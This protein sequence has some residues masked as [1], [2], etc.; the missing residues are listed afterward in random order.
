MLFRTRSVAKS[1]QTT[2]GAVMGSN[3]AVRAGV[4][5]LVALATCLALLMGCGGGDGGSTVGVKDGATTA[6][7]PISEGAAEATVDASDHDP[8]AL[9]TQADAE[10]LLG[11]TPDDPEVESKSCTWRTKKN[12]F[13]RL[14]I[15]EDFVYETYKNDSQPVTGVGDEAYRVDDDIY[16]KKGS[17]FFHV[18]IQG[19]GERDVEPVFQQ[20]AELVLKKL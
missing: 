16:V 1:C 2:K 15:D 4:G 18:H 9:L 12:G 19:L 17:L 8:C 6:T 3:K 7:Q 11:A 14:N 20:G 13:V 10:A 5:P